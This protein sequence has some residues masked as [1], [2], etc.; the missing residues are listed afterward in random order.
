MENSGSEI[1][2]DEILEFYSDK[3]VCLMLM[4]ISEEWCPVKTETE[5]SSIPIIDTSI[6]DLSTSFAVQ[7]ATTSQ[8]Y[9]LVSEDDFL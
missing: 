7:H 2:E 3:N 5:N 8:T 1:V 4:N 6:T 9:V